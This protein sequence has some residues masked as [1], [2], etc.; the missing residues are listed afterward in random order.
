M[1]HYI[2][3]ITFPSYENT[4]YCKNHVPLHDYV[5]FS[6]FGT[7]VAFCCPMLFKFSFQSDS[8]QNDRTELEFE[9]LL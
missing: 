8:S 7:S 4:T 5:N 1:S 3:K 6:F 2:L 9:I